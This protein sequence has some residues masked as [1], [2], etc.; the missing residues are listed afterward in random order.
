MAGISSNIFRDIRFFIL[1]WFLLH[2]VGITRPPIEPSHSWRQ[3]YTAMVAK[4]FYE[5]GPNI[6]Y[7]EVDYM[8]PGR[9]VTA[10]EFHFM[11]SLIWSVSNIFGYDHWYGRLINLV[12]STLGIWFFFLIIREWIGRREAF[13]STVVLMVSTW[14]MFSRKIMPDTFSVSLVII[15][16]YFAL[17]YF[18]SGSWLSLFIYLLAGTL[19]VLNK[20]PSAVLLPVLIIPLVA[21]SFPLLRKVFFS[22]ISLIII[23]VAGIWYFHWVP[24]LIAE[25]NNPLYFPRSFAEG[26]AEI[27]SHTGGSFEKFLFAALRSYAG[28]AIFL[29]GLILAIKEKNRILVFIFLSTLLLFLVFAVKAGIIF[30]THDYYIIP[31]VPVMALMAGFGLSKIKKPFLAYILLGI[32]TFE[33]TLN[34]YHD[35]FPGDANRYLLNLEQIGN[36][37]SSE[38]DLFIVNGGLDPRLMYFLDREGWSIRNVDACNPAV[39][40]SLSARGAEFLLLDETKGACD[41]DWPPL[42]ED[43]DVVLY[44]LV[45]R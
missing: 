20:I 16:I 41:V 22:I 19:G 13:F 17:D 26:L 7:P 34:Q 9:E 11:T 36:K 32:V 44:R 2:L 24:H 5:N 30:S 4:N 15:G 35:F 27:A 42:Y 28:F 29:F 12:F 23:A 25:Y 31:F 14:F 6:L 18:R 1:I 40:D 39:V 33:G 43:D 37:Y 45:L 8:G 38:D 21:G 3:A 10:S